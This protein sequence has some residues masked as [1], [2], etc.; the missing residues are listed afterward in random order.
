MVDCLNYIAPIN[1]L[2]YGICGLS[3]LKELY[4]L[5]WKIAWKPIGGCEVSQEHSQMLN[6]VYNNSFYPNA[7]S[8]RLF[9]EFDC[10]EHIG[11][12]RHLSWPIFE[13]TNFT[14]QRKRH[15]E[16]ASELIVCTN[17][18][19]DILQNN[20]FKQPIHVVPLGV[21]PD[22]F[23]RDEYSVKSKDELVFIHISKREY[24]KSQYEMLQCFEKAFTE[25]DRVKLIM[26]WGSPLLQQRNPSEWKQWTNLYRRSK[27]ASKIELVEWL[28]SQHEIVRLLNQADC[29]LFLSKAEGFGLGCLES[30]ACGL[31]NITLNYSGYTEFSNK[32]NSLLVDVTEFENIHDGVWFTEENMGQWAAFG[33]DQEEQTIH[34]MRDLYNKKMSGENL[35]NQAGVETGKRFTW[36]N[37]AKKLMDVLS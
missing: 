5:G 31:Q 17:W 9:H 11:H 26:I 32:N 25:K 7:P 28:P 15:L 24:R 37:S 10:A 34:H 20:G 13:I 16:A 12:G 36:E 23:K 27:L 18:A 35:H 3:I 30:L 22:L 14:G 19:K 4:K 8:V 21:D 6:E 33:S 2:S 1:Q 29:G